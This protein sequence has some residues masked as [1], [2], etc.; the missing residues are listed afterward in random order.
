MNRNNKEI[1]NRGTPEKEKPKEEVRS[2]H[3]PSESHHHQKQS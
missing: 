3:Q 1:A 2:Y